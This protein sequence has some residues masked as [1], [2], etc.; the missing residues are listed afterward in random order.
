MLACPLEPLVA[1]RTRRCSRCRA[2][3]SAVLASSHADFC[4]A[5]VSERKELAGT[6]TELCLVNFKGADGTV[7]PVN[8]PVARSRAASARLSACV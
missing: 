7:L 3:R 8:M 5:K 2:A 1:A 6:S 4:R